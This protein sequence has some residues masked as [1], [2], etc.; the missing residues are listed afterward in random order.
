VI[1]KQFLA[2]C[3]RCDA[4]A[5]VP[6]RILHIN[7]ETECGMLS[8]MGVHFVTIW[9]IRHKRRLF[10]TMLRHLPPYSEA[11][12]IL[13][14]DF[15]VTSN[16]DAKCSSSNGDMDFARSSIADAFD[17]IFSPFIEISQDEFT[18]RR[19]GSF[20]RID[21]VYINLRSSDWLDLEVGGRTAWAWSSRKAASSDHLPLCLSLGKATNQHKKHT[22]LAW[23][24]RII[25]SILVTLLC[26]MVGLAKI[27]C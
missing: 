13:G 22:S 15:N 24:A 4:R 12:S 11:L 5:L 21:R 6:G 8:I 27:P 14:G 17:C 18:W 23:L 3:A 25:P 19:R 16:G 2:F 26:A 1:A 10:Y 7:F 9:D 20:S